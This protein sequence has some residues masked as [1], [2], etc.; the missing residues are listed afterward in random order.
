LEIVQVFRSEDILVSQMISA[1]VCDLPFITKT[2]TPT[3]VWASHNMEYQ[4]I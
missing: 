4:T 3:N 1:N 2:H